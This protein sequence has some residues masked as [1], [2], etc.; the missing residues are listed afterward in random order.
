[1]YLKNLPLEEALAT[2][3]RMERMTGRTNFMAADQNN[4]IYP[5]DVRLDNLYL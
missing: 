4:Y 1:V 3:N 5:P 2:V